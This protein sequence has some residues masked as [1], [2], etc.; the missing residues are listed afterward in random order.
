M[1]GEFRMRWS[2]FGSGLDV[3][4][5]GDI[6]FKPDL[7]DVESLSDGGYL[8]IRT[9]SLFIPRTIEIRSEGGRLTH[10]YYVA[11][12]SRPYDN[13][14]RRW[15]ASELST[16]LVRKVGL[17]AES[18][19]RQIL[20]AGGVPAVLE[21]I[22][23][24]E[25]DYVRS[26][27][28]RELFRS[29]QLASTS[30]ARALALAASV[31]DSDFELSRTLRAAAPA[32][33]LDSQTVQAYVNAANDIHSDF[34]RRRA[35]VTLLQVDG[36]AAGTG[37]VV[38]QSAARMGSDF[39]KGR[40][41]RSALETPTLDRAEAL[42]PALRTMSSDFEKRRVISAVMARADLS[43]EARKGLLAGAAD[44]DSDFECATA[45]I[46][47]A[48]KFGTDAATADAFFAA[49][50]TIDSAFETKRVLTAVVKKTP[51]APEVSRGVF[52]TVRRM[53]SDFERAQVLLT[54]VGVQSLD[55]TARSGFIAAAESLGSTY[56]QNGVLA[57]LFKAE[58]R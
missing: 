9:W 45:L 13:E 2:N 57:A 6:T 48:N 39:E 7:S 52:D 58:R 4:G 51:L 15:L 38:L 29:P 14:A 41:L 30:L 22:H 54:M 19:T 42:V 56:E 17:G 34:E 33:A 8:S 21:E 40:V 5:R 12:L 27:Y 36:A 20:A 25:G 46:A 50:R 10:R 18:R 31:I 53:S 37:D 49:L 32:A 43:A 44:I 24:L 11:G 23:R 47:F 28:F 3:R 55:A 16:T 35:L 26:R 1:R